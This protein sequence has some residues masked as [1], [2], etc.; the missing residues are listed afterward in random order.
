MASEEKIF[1]YL[2]HK[3]YILVAE[4]NGLYKIH[5]VGRGL[6]KEHF[7]KFFVKISAVR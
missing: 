7:C 2:F 4:F 5:M 1:E 6:L 3:I